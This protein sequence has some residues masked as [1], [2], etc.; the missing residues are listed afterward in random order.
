MHTTLT[1]LF[2]KNCLKF[3]SSSSFYFLFIVLSYLIVWDYERA[4]ILP[5][6]LSNASTSKVNLM[7]SAA[8]LVLK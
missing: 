6:V 5:A 2:C 1:F 8:A 7:A 4:S 3:T